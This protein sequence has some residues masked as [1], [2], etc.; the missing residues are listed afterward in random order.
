MELRSSNR[1]HHS[2]SGRPPIGASGQH[3]LLPSDPK[4]LQTLAHISDKILLTCAGTQPPR[5]VSLIPHSPVHLDRAHRDRTSTLLPRVTGRRS[6]PTSDHHH[7]RISRAMREGKHPH[8]AAKA[9]SEL[10]VIN[11]Q[12]PHQRAACRLQA[13]NGSRVTGP[14][15]SA[16]ITS[17]TPPLPGQ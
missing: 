1:I 3:S 13:W 11:A 7:S 15:E 8:R 17:A 14:P 5:S 12:S 4:P 10:R 6:A 9:G 2:A 16:A